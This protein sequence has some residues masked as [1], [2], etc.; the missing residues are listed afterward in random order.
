MADLRVFSSDSPTIDSQKG[1]PA[2]FQ[3]VLTEMDIWVLSKSLGGTEL[4]GARPSS[5]TGV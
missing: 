5:V 3:N 2:P 4:L 1:K